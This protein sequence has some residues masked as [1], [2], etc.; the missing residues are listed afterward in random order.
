MDQQLT[1]SVLRSLT[2]S[3]KTKASALQPQQQQQQGTSDQTNFW[4]IMSSP[5]SDGGRLHQNEA[6]QPPMSCADFRLHG[7][8]MI[9]YIA[10][11][12][13][14]L[15]ERRVTPTVQPG[16]LRPRLPASPPTEPQPWADIMSDVDKH[17][18]EGMTHWQH[19]DFHAYFGTGNSFPSIMADML[20]NA[21]GCL[22]FSWVRAQ[23]P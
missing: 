8:V 17:I 16:Y 19:P 3:G 4:Q 12:L 15:S 7:K 22:G 18:M 20:A 13:E 11:Y 10:D 14:G 2:L 1:D 6:A 5:V 21:M 9:D 23:Y